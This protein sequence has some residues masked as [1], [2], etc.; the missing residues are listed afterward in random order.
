MG[1]SHYT[2]ENTDAGVPTGTSW[3]PA[4]GAEPMTFAPVTMDEVTEGLRASSSSTGTYLIDK[5]RL[6]LSGEE[7]E[8]FSPTR[9]VV[10]SMQ[11]FHAAKR[12]PETSLLISRYLRA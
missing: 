9:G 3:P 10:A 12:S 4:G 2:V 1:I 5:E 7:T 11:R 8:H 6:S